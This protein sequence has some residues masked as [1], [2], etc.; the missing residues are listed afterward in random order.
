MCSLTPTPP[1]PLLFN[2]GRN[3]G[4]SHHKAKICFL[5]PSGAKKSTLKLGG[6]GGRDCLMN[7]VL[8]RTSRGHQAVHDTNLSHV[9][10]ALAPMRVR[11]A[12]NNYIV[13]FGRGGSTKL[14]L[15]STKYLMID[16]SVPQWFHA[17]RQPSRIQVVRPLLPQAS[18]KTHI[19]YEGCLWALSFGSS[20]KA[21]IRRNYCHLN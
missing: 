5:V 19:S 1:D 6:K 12:K 2:V 4:S 8:R 17:P 16:S 13:S 10:L 14:L 21:I 9:T 11:G 3:K 15:S 7:L 20:L 18:A